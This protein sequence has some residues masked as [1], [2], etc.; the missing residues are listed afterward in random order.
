MGCY[1]GVTADLQAPESFESVSYMRR[2]LIRSPRA[3]ISPK[4][5][6]EGC[7]I[8]AWETYITAGAGDGFEF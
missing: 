4:P 3:V 6:F 2:L 7:S 5:R 8:V 1:R